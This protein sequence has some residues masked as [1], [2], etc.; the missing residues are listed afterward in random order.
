MAPAD[1]D[2]T[3]AAW[4]T[5]A[6]PADVDF[7]D[8]AAIRRMSADYM[9]ETGGPAP[10]YPHPSVTLLSTTIAGVGCLVWL[11]R[12][13]HE[14]R[15]AVIAAHGGGFIVGSA[16]GAE[17]IAVPLA[18]EH[19]IITVSVE[20]RLAPEHRAPAALDDMCAVVAA[21]AGDSTDL[22][23]DAQRLAVHGSSAGACL[24]AG[25][26]QWARDTGLHLSGQS[27]SC[28]ALDD[29]TWDDVW[30]PTWTTQ[31][32]AWM[33]R[34][35]LPPG[36]PPAYV[37]PARC[38]N[39]AGLAP[40]HL[41]I[42]QYDTLRSQAVSYAQRLSDADVSVEVHD[43]PGTVHGFDGLLPNSST[44]QRAITSQITAITHWLNPDPHP[45]N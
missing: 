13:L 6:P 38:D 26:A 31:A 36:E 33:W 9:R 40:A 4:L 18:A 35:Y 16:L 32:T 20:Y 17:R 23:V 42:A 29:R 44:A 43:A 41:V 3:I 27:L 21:L 19:Q 11:P 10:R 7:A 12:D 24:A 5:A 14:P 34:H 15:P 45:H 28:P 25:T 30:S 8:I 22:P 39:L 1:L 2:P 37:I